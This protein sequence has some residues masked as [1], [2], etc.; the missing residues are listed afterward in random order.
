M[1]L[2]PHAYKE[3]FQATLGGGTRLC[4]A[5]WESDI[6][7]D[8]HYLAEKVFQSEKSKWLAMALLSTKACADEPELRIAARILFDE[9][10]IG[11]SQERRLWIDARAPYQRVAPQVMQRLAHRAGIEAVYK[12]AETFAKTFDRSESRCLGAGQFEYVRV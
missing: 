11:S 3:A 6:E 1:D 5:E 12:S 2:F 8:F 9:A 7:A 10:I 4:F